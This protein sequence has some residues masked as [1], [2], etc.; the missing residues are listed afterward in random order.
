[1]L[2][3][4][5]NH[6]INAA[7]RAIQTFKDHFVSALATTDNKFPLQLWD[8]LAPQVEITLN[9][10]CPLQIDPTMLGYVAI[11]RPYN[12]NRFL[13]APPVC[14]AVIY[15]S[16]KAHTSWGSCITNAWYLGLSLDHYRFNHY[17]VPKTWAY[18]ISRSAN[19]FPQHCQVLFLMWN[20]HLQELIDE[21][22]TTLKEM[23]PE[24]QTSVLTLV[25]QKLS[26]DQIH[27]PKWSLTCSGHK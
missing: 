3:E 14:K 20:K 26:T 27:E 17:F 4:P 18:C 25:E 19:L 13:L 7:K 11:H 10:L 6:C 9:M 22:V 24:K 1:M 5:H 23:P 12:W 15:E 8:Q 2:V 21:L 16:P